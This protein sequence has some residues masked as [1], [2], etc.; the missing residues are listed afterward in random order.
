MGVRVQAG[1]GACSGQAW[2]PSVEMPRLSRRHKGNRMSPIIPPESL[3]VPQRQQRLAVC[4][5]RMVVGDG[6]TGG[7]GRKNRLTTT[8]LS[9]TRFLLMV[10]DFPSHFCTCTRAPPSKVMV[11]CGVRGSRCDLTCCRESTW[12]L[13]RLAWR[14]PWGH[15]KFYVMRLYC[16]RH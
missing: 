4:L 10:V 7:S 5:G 14:P 6:L 9:S 2:L 11:L 13:R 3:L 8:S 15:S 16:H 1:C 12:K